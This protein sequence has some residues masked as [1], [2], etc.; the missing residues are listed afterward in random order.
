VGADADADAVLPGAAGPGTLVVDTAPPAVGAPSD[1]AVGVGLVD[2]SGVVALASAPP[3]GPVEEE[4][5]EEDA[6]SPEQA[7][8][9]SASSST[10]SRDGRPA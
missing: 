10:A 9:T 6:S 7:W 8:S 4:E 5:E 1:R 3:A 2:V